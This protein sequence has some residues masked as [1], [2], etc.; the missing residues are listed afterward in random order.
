VLTSETQT[1]DALVGR[2]RQKG[3]SCAQPHSPH[4]AALTKGHKWFVEFE[5][6]ADFGSEPAETQAFFD[7]SPMP[8]AAGHGELAAAEAAREQGAATIVVTVMHQRE[9]GQLGARSSAVGL[10]H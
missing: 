1:L 10:C 9:S 3:W 8:A 4:Q 6:V 2:L 5:N 7:D